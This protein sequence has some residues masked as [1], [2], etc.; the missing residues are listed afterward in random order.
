MFKRP[1]RSELT[2]TQVREWK[3]A[4]RVASAFAE[5]MNPEQ[6]VGYTE[7]ELNGIAKDDD[8]LAEYIDDAER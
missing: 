4:K 8:E 5:N 7:D 2:L 3:A 1:M 6:F